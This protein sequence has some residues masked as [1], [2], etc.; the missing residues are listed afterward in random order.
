LTADAINVFA[1]LS[2]LDLKSLW[3]ELD[4]YDVE[5]DTESRLLQEV[6]LKIAELKGGSENSAKE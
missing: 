6:W 1:M 4:E 3:K 2:E 5:V